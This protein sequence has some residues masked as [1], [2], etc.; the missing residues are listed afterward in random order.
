MI[1]KNNLERASRQRS[2]VFGN[3]TLARNKQKL[4]DGRPG[5]AGTRGLTFP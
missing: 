3:R 2:S 4:G 5:G 1:L